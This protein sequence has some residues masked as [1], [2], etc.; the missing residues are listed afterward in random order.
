[1]APRTSSPRVALAAVAA[2]LVVAGCATEAEAPPAAS[3]LALGDSYT[4]GESVPAADRWPVRLVDALARLNA[5]D[6]VDV[7]LLVRGGGSAEDLWAFN[8]ERLAR[9]IAGSRI[10]VVAAVGHETDVTI[11]GMAADVRAP[12]PS[13]AAE[14]AVPDAAGLE[15]SVK[16]FGGDLRREVLRRLRDAQQRADGLGG[17]LTPQILIAKLEGVRHR[18]AAALT[19]LD[20]VRRGLQLRR[21]TLGAVLGRLEALSPRTTLRRGFAIAI[22]GERV[23]ATVAGLAA[24]DSLLV[25]LQDG[26]V[27]CRVVRTKRR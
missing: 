16:T 24:G 5:R 6:D 19:G 17:A 26:D 22:K 1:M 4:I 18:L 21:Q 9:A 13:A 3:Y 12:T 2:S 11:A 20:E 15:S 8:D 10:P 27:E 14:L 25:M 7:I 23:V